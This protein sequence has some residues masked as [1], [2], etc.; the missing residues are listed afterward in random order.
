VLLRLVDRWHATEEDASREADV[1]ACFV[2]V[3]ESYKAR[4]EKKFGEHPDR[5]QWLV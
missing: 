1:T 3:F 4:L 2:A 5:G